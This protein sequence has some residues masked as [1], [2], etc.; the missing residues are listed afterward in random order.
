MNTTITIS[1]IC[2]LII[3]FLVFTQIILCS[4]STQVDSDLETIN[5][6]ID[7]LEVENAN[8]STN[9][10]AISNSTQ[11]MTAIPGQTDFSNSVDVTTELYI[12]SV[13]IGQTLKQITTDID[14]SISDIVNLTVQ[15]VITT[16]S[17]SS[18]NGFFVSPFGYIYAS[19]SSGNPNSNNFRLHEIFPIICTLAVV[20][21]YIRDKDDSYTINPGCEITFFTGAFFTGNPSSYYNSTSSQTWQLS[22][23]GEKCKSLIVYFGKYAFN[24]IQFPIPDDLLIAP[25]FR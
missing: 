21:S 13:A 7:S 24:P 11:N 15:N 4:G 8:N 14:S 10:N 6:D 23:S 12:Q 16:N 18:Q 3:L 5:Q 2:G 19:D 17:I 20:P 1:I 9:L 22:V 25:R